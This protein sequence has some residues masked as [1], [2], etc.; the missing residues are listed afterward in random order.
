MLLPIITFGLLVTLQPSSISKF[1]FISFCLIVLV[2]YFILKN[3]K[4]EKDI[5]IK[6]DKFA[7]LYFGLG[8][9]LFW[10]RFYYEPEGMWDAWAAWNAKAKDLSLSFL[11]G[12]DFALYRDYWLNPQY[13]I[14][15]PLQIS[16]F[17]IFLGHW[18]P[19]VPI[20][21][22]YSYYLFLFIIVSSIANRVSNTTL[23]KHYILLLSLAHP[24]Y[25]NIASDQCA[26][27][28]VSQLLLHS[29]LAIY[30]YFEF[31]IKE[32]L[33]LF[34]LSIVFLINTKLEGGVFSIILLIVFIV[35]QFFSELKIRIR[36]IHLI[37]L[38]ITV[39]GAI[40]FI[41]YKYSTQ[42]FTTYKLDPVTVFRNFLDWER[43]M[44]VFSYLGLFFLLLFLRLS[45]YLLKSG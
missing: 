36:N 13:P 20:F 31:K 4:I 25:I 19:F 5:N 14:I 30:F 43:H 2:N 10:F 35:K 8:S 1:R 16:F 22:G 37:S 40:L 34:L 28:I 42:Q 18:T 15:L 44:K 29:F 24:L 21:L 32:G 45:F 17:T 27:L 12:Y 23:L 9:L 11:R 33:S 26:D 3:W 41:Y 38:V 7:L 39:F 6:I